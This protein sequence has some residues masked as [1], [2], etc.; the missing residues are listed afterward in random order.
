MTK[1]LND[2]GIA[3]IC[4]M[5]DAWP[6]DTPLTWETLVAGVGG[7]LGVSYTRQALGAHERIARAYRSRRDVLSKMPPPKRAGDAAMEAALQQIEQLKAETTRIKDENE[8]LKEKFVR[9]AYNAHSRGLTPEML[10]S[11]LPSVDRDRTRPEPVGKR[12]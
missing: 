8:R 12:K 9:W 6:S 7:R 2:L 11:P 3:S 1:R 10:E 5:I 4:E